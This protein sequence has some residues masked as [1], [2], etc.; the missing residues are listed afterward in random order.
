MN[1]LIQYFYEKENSEA[2]KP[3]LHQPFGEQWETYTREKVG[4]K[5]I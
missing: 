2:D 5:A 3:F 4:L 1:T